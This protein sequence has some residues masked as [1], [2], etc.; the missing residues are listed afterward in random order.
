MIL[1]YIQCSILSKYLYEI[2]FYI[3]HTKDSYFILIF[4]FLIQIQNICV[5]IYIYINIDFEL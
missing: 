5:Y 3:T 4:N 1:L 2:V